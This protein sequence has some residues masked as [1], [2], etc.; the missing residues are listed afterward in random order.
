MAETGDKKDALS[1]FGFQ[2]CKHTDSLTEACFYFPAATFTPSA[3]AQL[4]YNA[5]HGKESSSN[6]G[7]HS[8][9]GKRGPSGT[10]SKAKAK[11]KKASRRSK[12]NRRSSE[13]D[14]RNFG[15]FIQKGDPNR[16]GYGLE[17]I[18][19][20]AARYKVYRQCMER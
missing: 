18:S 11:R 6:A 3:K 13:F 4:E 2:R 15:G 19:R 5:E 7:K 10:K 20:V 9:N 17:P 12:G 1:A 14:N 16:E 8:G